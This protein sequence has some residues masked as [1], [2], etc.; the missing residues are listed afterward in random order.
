MPPLNYRSI[1]GPAGRFVAEIITGGSAATSRATTAAPTNRADVNDYTTGRDPTY[2][3]PRGVADAQSNGFSG[4]VAGAGKNTGAPTSATGIK[5]N[6]LT[7]SPIP[8]PFRTESWL[9]MLADFGIPA[10]FALPPTPLALD[11]E[12]ATN[13]SANAIFAP[14]YRARIIEILSQ[15]LPL[16]LLQSCEDYALHLLSCTTSLTHSGPDNRFTQ[17]TRP[18]SADFVEHLNRLDQLLS[19]ETKNR[20]VD[21]R[22]ITFFDVN[23]KVVSKL[24]SSAKIPSLVSFVRAVRPCELDAYILLGDPFGSGVA[25][26]HREALETFRHCLVPGALLLLRNVSVFCSS[27]VERV[28]NITAANIVRIY[29]PSQVL[30]LYPTVMP[31][32]RSGETM[33]ARRS[34]TATPIS[35]SSSL[36]SKSAGYNTSRDD[37]DNELFSESESED[38]PN[39]TAADKEKSAKSI[40]EA[41]ELFLQARNQRSLIHQDTGD[42]GRKYLRP[43][44]ASPL[45]MAPVPATTGFA[46][47]R[48]GLPTYAPA[49]SPTSAS[50]GSF[51]SLDH[52]TTRRT[53]L[54]GGPSD[55]RTS[56]VEKPRTHAPFKPPNQQRE[57][58]A[59]RQVLTPQ[60][61]APRGAT[62][63]PP[64][65]RPPSVTPISTSTVPGSSGEP[66][67]PASSQGE[68]RDTAS[69]VP[70]PR[71][72]DAAGNTSGEHQGL[73]RSNGIPSS[74][75]SASAR[76]TVERTSTQS[77]QTDKATSGY[78]EL[79]SNIDSFWETD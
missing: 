74:S 23:L 6:P 28:V 33:D 27:P 73:S 51:Q 32:I 70:T 75:A 34:N 64:G 9:N 45:S 36:R 55:P 20:I 66:R 12:D 50:S 24:E 59:S 61:Q 57:T 10:S 37:N 49:A 68:Q 17:E 47:R 14:R 54:Q 19:P 67:R 53:Y 21:D 35:L 3:S 79:L 16:D 69:G 42:L 26:V 60:M 43:D 41:H 52:L 48:T 65:R 18:N 2:P 15:V 77:T 44:T 58:D 39:E 25:C 29:P 7:H 30:P 38:S 76:P 78:T 5:L 22:R 56:P 4:A 46:S 40:A 62:P 13:S 63:Q 8:I 1:P 72:T 11:P 31:F 71:G